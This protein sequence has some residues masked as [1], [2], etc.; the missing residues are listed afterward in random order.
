MSTKTKSKNSRSSAPRG[1]LEDDK[2]DKAPS[3]K[4]LWMRAADA[5]KSTLQKALGDLEKPVGQF[6][7]AVKKGKGSAVFVS[8]KMRE[9]ATR[10]RHGRPRS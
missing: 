1:S 10:W 6:E 7:T 2:A 8:T 3:K 5:T 4:A 9:V